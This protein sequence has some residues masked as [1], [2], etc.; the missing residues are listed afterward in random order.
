MRRRTNIRKSIGGAMLRIL[1]W[2]LM[3]RV[4]QWTPFTSLV[5]QERAEIFRFPVQVCSSWQ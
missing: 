4:V 3:M 5:L 2:Q 1:G